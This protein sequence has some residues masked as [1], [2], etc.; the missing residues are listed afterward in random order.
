MNYAIL[1]D[2]MIEYFR[3]DSKRIQHFLKVYS[4]AETIGKLENL[5]EN[6][7]HIV[8][9][10]T[11]VHDI[12]IKVSEKK[13]NSSAGNLQEKEGPPIAEEMLTVLGFDKNTIQRV[14]WLVAHHH[15]YHSIDSID[16]QILVEADFIVNMCE[17]QMPLDSVQSVYNNIFR[18][19]AGKNICRNLFALNDIGI[20][21]VED[22]KNDKALRQPNITPERRST[23][24]ISLFKETSLSPAYMVSEKCNGCGTCIDVCPAQCIEAQRT[25]VY[26]RQE[27][28][29][30]CGSCANVCDKNAILRISKQ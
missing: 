23:N 15:T 17:D 25:P 29:L 7:L 28:C 16:H 8:K 18:T 3:G 4:F 5:D 19:D 12:G 24:M 11:I 27:D 2:K 1:I 21:D 6:L 13:Y 30:H 20:T 14:S 10:A 22:T 9:T 26:I